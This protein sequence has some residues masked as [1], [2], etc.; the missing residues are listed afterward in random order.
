[1]NGDQFEVGVDEKRDIKAEARN[2]FGGLLD[3]LL[4]VKS[5]VL[6]IR[7]EIVDRNVRDCERLLR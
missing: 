2:T 7:F 6:W 5:R 4:T 1:V 3:L